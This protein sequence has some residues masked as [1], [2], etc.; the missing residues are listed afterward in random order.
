MYNGFAELYD[1]LMQDVNYGTWADFYVRLMEL[2]GIRKGKICECACGTGA[3][4]IPLYRRGFQMTGVDL[5]QEMLWVASQKARKSGAAIPFIC[6][7]MRSLH[8]H[9]PVDA[10]LATC[11]GVNYLLRDEDVLRFF[12]SA[13][14]SLRP[15]GA[16]L[17]DISTP[18]KLQH[19]LGDRLIWEDGD[20]ITFLWENHFHSRTGLVDMN[21]RFFV[22]QE[23]GRYTRVDE[24]QKQRA[25]EMEQIMR[26]LRDAGFEQIRVFANGSLNPPS[27]KEERWHFTAMRRAE[28]GGKTE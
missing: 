17:F 16:L 21:L 1:E 5:S 27:E 26:L 23:D 18:Y 2:C 28:A 22:R 9:K 10:V 15:G 4:T 24:E 13:Y 25:H 8:L 3:L 14:A 11:D 19:L 6:Q 20:H 7:D 12:R